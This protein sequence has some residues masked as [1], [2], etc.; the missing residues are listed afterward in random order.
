MYTIIL[1]IIACILLRESASLIFAI[2]RKVQQY[3]YITYKM[4]ASV[5][6]ICL[7]HCLSQKIPIILISECTVYHCNFINNFC[8]MQTYRIVLFDCTYCAGLVDI[9]CTCSYCFLYR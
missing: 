6:L 7:N 9:H 4:P 1:K 3:L 2:L 5:V 8:A